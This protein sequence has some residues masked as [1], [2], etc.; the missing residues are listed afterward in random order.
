MTNTTAAKHRALAG[1]L[2]L[3]LAIAASGAST[4]AAAQ[5]TP[6]Q[7]SRTMTT[8]STAPAADTLSA[9]QQAI[10]PPI[11]AF[12]A[13]GDIAKLN[14]ALN[15][16]LDAGLTIS[17]AREVLVQLYAYAGFP[18]SLNA[19]TELMKVLDA[20]KQRGI[21]DAPGR[22]PSH[23]IPKGDALRAA[24]TANQ[25]KLVGQP[26]AGPIFEFAPAIGE[27]LQAH[28]FGA[29]FERDNLDWQSREL[30]TVAMLSALPGA[31]GQLQGHVGYS[32]N[33]GLTAEQMRQAVQVLSERVGADSGRRASEAL[34]KVLAARPR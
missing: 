29:I 20:R 2:A 6:A 9:Q 27:Y 22:E 3:G 4:R 1:A 13:A 26:V 30:A 5:T 28:L 16:G 25:T 31:E 23:A 19:L 24:G 8:Q 11:A 12:A 15:Q 33:T 10:L 7:E 18:R 17:D 14:T 34:A 32:M 21:Q